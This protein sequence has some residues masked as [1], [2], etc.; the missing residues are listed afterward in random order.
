MKEIVSAQNSQFKYW[1]SLLRSK[2]LRESKHFLLSGKKLVDEILDDPIWNKKVQTVL[3]ESISDSNAISQWQNL[4][5]SMP[6]VLLSSPLF[7]ELDI[8]GAGGPI[9]V[10]EQPEIQMWNLQ[11][12]PQGFELL[13]PLGDPQNLGAVIRSAY[14]FGVDS[15]VLLKEAAHP[16]LPK[17]IKASSGA[18]L[19]IPLKQG[20]SI[21]QIGAVKDLTDDPN[22]IIK[23]SSSNKL[24]LT[25]D[26]EKQVKKSQ[27]GDGG[28]CYA[29]DLEGTEI[30]LKTGALN[31]SMRL[32]LGEEGKGIPKT[33]SG[34][35]LRLP[36]VNPM[37]SLNVAVATSIAIYEIK[38]AG[39]IRGVGKSH[40]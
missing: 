2:G 36:M 25:T 28:P 9:L 22:P 4:F 8:L 10:M 31:S 12:S 34:E 15:I 27:R 24:N 1:K 11:G 33:F 3:I 37:E 38:R 5:H 6:G 14:A 13:C 26:R 7:K 19:R 39:L 32:L 18:V 40:S 20:P 29:L 17:A 30:Y 16:F 35:R 21:R 23:P